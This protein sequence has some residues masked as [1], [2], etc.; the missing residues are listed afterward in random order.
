MTP[1]ACRASNS[2][3]RLASRFEAKPLVRLFPYFVNGFT[4]N[5]I[6]PD[7]PYLIQSDM[8]IRDYSRT[9]GAFLKGL[10]P[11]GFAC[12]SFPPV[13][14]QL[15]IVIHYPITCI[16]I[17]SSFTLPHFWHTFFCRFSTAAQ[18]IHFFVICLEDTLTVYSC[19]LPHLCRKHIINP[20]VNTPLER[21]VCIVSIY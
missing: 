2:A 12:H 3:A 16:V 8:G 17:S 13:N 5:I 9:A 14:I 1:A 18:S 21:D 10:V 11:P 20:P 19:H 4:L 6:R 15:N 7:F